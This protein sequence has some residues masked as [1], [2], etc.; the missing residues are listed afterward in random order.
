MGVL[1]K[2]GIK[3][4][5]FRNR[6]EIKPEGDG[7][8]G[9]FDGGVFRIEISY[10]KRAGAPFCLAVNKLKNIIMAEEIY[11][12]KSTATFQLQ[13]QMKKTRLRE[14]YIEYPGN[15]LRLI[16][17][18]ENGKAEHWE[19]A[20]IC[21][22][23]QVFL[24]KQRTYEF[25]FFKNTTGEICCPEFDQKWPQLITICG[26]HLAS[27]KGILPVS[28]YIPT[29]QKKYTNIPPKYGVVKWWNIAQGFGVIETKA[30]TA[31]VHWKSILPNSHKLL[32]LFPGQM[33]SC[34]ELIEN[35]SRQSKFSLEAIGV[36]PV[37]N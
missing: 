25:Q 8:L 4:T 30:G 23:N 11:P 33:V 18:G 17:F 24:T 9:K 13:V 7:F 22:N 2:Q 16:L 12:Q 5:V 27:K 28:Q 15:N 37:K 31:K 3:I 34:Q 19:I 32:Q 14:N 20:V 26:S 6:Q 10:E 35:Q 29:R 1:E 21:Q 36:A